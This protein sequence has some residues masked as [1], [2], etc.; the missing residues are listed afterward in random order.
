MTSKKA[1]EETTNF[2]VTTLT[3]ICQATIIKM[4]EDI[5][6]AATTSSSSTSTSIATAAKSSSM[7][8]R[9]IHDLCK[10]LPDNLLGNKSKFLIPDASF[11]EANFTQSPSSL[12]YYQ[13]LS[14]DS[15]RMWCCYPSSYRTAAC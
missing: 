2:T 7:R 3:E 15:L 8:N 5:S 9:L 13:C 10:Y 12:C 11:E 14:A 6:I 4:L 1:E